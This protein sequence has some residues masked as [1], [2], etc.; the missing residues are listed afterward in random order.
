MSK[1]FHSVT[2]DKDKCRG[3][4]NCIKKCPT[5][6]IRVREGKAQII[7]EKCID[8]GECIKVCPYHAKVA[9]TDDISNIKNYKYKIA[10]P[11]PSFYGQFKELSIDEILSAL[12]LCGFD[13]VFEVAYAAEVVSK[14]TREFIKSKK[15]KKPII[16]SA[17]PAIV[18]LIQ[19][20]FPSLIDNI[21]NIVSPMEVA[22]KIARNLAHKKTRI[23]KKNIGV[24]FI[25]PCAAKV[26]S[27]KN[28]IGIEKS[29][30]DGVFSFRDIYSVII[31]N[32]KKIT[33]DLK[34]KSSSLG[35]GW[36]NS[37][38]ESYGTLLDNYLFVDGIHNVINVL[39][40][41]ELD[42]LNDIEFF[43]GLACIGGCV[44][45]PLTVENNFVAR[46]RIK[47]LTETLPKT[48]NIDIKDIKYTDFT[49]NKELKKN[50]VL[51][52]DYDIKKAINMMKEVDNIY[53]KLPGLDC[54]SCGSPGCRA[55]AED[56]VKGFANEY[57]CI[58]R[59]KDRIKEL[60]HE[61]N[62]LSIKLPPVINDKEDKH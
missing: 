34:Q 18:R 3:C 24:F 7:K 27:V 47:K 10:L 17:C 8:C 50:D 55:L 61:I 2:L 40:E 49:F 38:G 54:G 22:G 39:E 57:D 13:E 42:K 48:S 32:K 1:Y 21:L 56:I 20:R 44:G 29:S 28:P 6:A 4:T 58:F 5:E 46:N 33:D 30:I 26:T 9:V 52:L 36:A 41:F 19:L 51:N 37:G 31:D 14:M 25:S 43:E 45:G 53:E 60:A 16:S 15:L 35:V 59:L 62:E 11:A 12:Q 23:S